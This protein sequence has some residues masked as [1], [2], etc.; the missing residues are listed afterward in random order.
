[1]RIS[2]RLIDSNNT[3]IEKDVNRKQNLD[4]ND[5]DIIKQQKQNY[6]HSCIKTSDSS[7]NV[8][9]L[10]ECDRN[11]YSRNKHEKTQGQS[12][13]KYQEKDSCKNRISHWKLP[14]IPADNIE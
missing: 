9:R 13:M 5:Y 11:I 12:E 10:S 7:N 4:I 1:M 8:E 2:K 6:L 3:Q 14:S